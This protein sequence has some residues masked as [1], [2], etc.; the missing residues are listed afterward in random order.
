MMKRKKISG[1]V[2]HIGGKAPNQ[3]QL[4]VGEL[5]RHALSDI[6]ARG[7]IRDP[8]LAKTIIT[9]SE[10][11]MTP[12]LRRAIIF[13]APLSVG[14][15]AAAVKKGPRKADT[16]AIPAPAPDQAT[17]LIEALTRVKAFLRGEL[18]R[19]IELRHMPDL[20]FVQD[21]SF[22]Y[23]D[24]VDRV[25]RSQTV[26]RDLAPPPAASGASDPQD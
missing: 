25:L 5:I 13:V 12:D 9:V 15:G 21:T 1:H 3:R 10:V 6:L 20:S 16:S 11:R 17:A 2:R 18:A 4:R 26:Q 23:A 7:D 14:Q 19:E 8:F 24:S 22:D